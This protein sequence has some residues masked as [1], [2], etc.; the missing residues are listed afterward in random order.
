MTSSRHRL[1]HGSAA[2]SLHA[3]LMSRS[4]A[5]AGKV[6][7]ERRSL[8]RNMSV[9]AA[10]HTRATNAKSCLRSIGVGISRSP[11]GENHGAK[12]PN[13]RTPTQLQCFQDLLDVLSSSGV[14]LRK[15]F[16]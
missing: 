13:M 3:M 11:N 9:I 7:G 10:H 12:K 16:T 14:F 5:L 6:A 4:R 15:R 2:R 8:A 1:T